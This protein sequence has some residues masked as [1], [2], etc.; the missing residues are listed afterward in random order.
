MVGVLEM[1]E[2][3]LTQLHMLALDYR[4]ALIVTPAWDALVAYVESI[5]A[6]KPEPPHK[7]RYL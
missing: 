5:A 4:G 6:V 2:D 3:Q 1:T 7:D